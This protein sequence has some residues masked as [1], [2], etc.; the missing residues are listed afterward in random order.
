M[1][2]QPVRSG[3]QSILHLIALSLL[4]AAYT[5]GMNQV[6]HTNKIAVP[7]TVVVFSDKPRLCS[8]PTC[9]LHRTLCNRLR[10]A[11]P[12]LSRAIVRSIY[13]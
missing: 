9:H 13:A 3:N 2:N 6:F 12:H 11:L 8:S 10:T 7:L 4:N 1:G 5:T